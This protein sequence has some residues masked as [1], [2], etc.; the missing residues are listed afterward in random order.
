MMESCLECECCN[1]VDNSLGANARTIVVEQMVRHRR[2]WPT[3]TA[4]T[5]VAECSC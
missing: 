3:N 5:V 4:R 1:L 2:P